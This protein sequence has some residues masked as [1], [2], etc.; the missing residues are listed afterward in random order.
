[1]PGTLP[2]AIQGRDK[3]IQEVCDNHRKCSCCTCPTYVIIQLWSCAEENN[4]QHECTQKQILCRVQSCPCLFHLSGCTDVYRGG[5]L[6]VGSFGVFN[7]TWCLYV[8]TPTHFPVDIALWHDWEKRR[9]SCARDNSISNDQIGTAVERL[10]VENYP[11]PA[12]GRF[13]VAT[14]AICVAASAALFLLIRLIITF[15]YFPVTWGV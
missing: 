10:L 15:T 8:T 13:G 11:I 4:L 5:T 14:L 9:Y 7:F 12:M 6:A 2:C 3:T 1:M